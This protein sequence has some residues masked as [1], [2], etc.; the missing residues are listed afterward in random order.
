MKLPRQIHSQSN[1]HFNL[2]FKLQKTTL[3][4]VTVIFLVQFFRLLGGGFIGGEFSKTDK[5]EFL[6][7]IEMPKD[8]SIEQTNFMTQKQKL[9]FKKIK[10]L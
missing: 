6:V 10:I 3:A 5:G 7:Q 8:V 9:Y 4:I 2:V 1:R